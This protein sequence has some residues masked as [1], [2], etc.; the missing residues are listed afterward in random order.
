MGKGITMTIVFQAQSL[1]YG[2]GVSNISELKKLTRMDG[3]QYTFVSRQAIRFDIVR[4]GHEIFEWNLQVVDKSKGTVQF[5]E[6]ATIKDSV[7]MDLFGYMKT[8]KKDEE[9]KGGSFVRPAVVRLSNAISLEPYRSD[10]DFLSNKGLADRI[11]EHP[12]LANSEQHMS[13]YTYTV[14]IDLDRIGVDNEISLEKTER[15]KRI[16]QLLDIIKI[17]NRNIRGRQENLSPLF[18]I[19]GLYK[20]S[21]P[22]FLGR[23]KLENRNG[24]YSINENIIKDTLE[25]TFGDKEIKDDTYIGIVDGIFI[26]KEEFEKILPDK[27]VNVEKFFEILKEKVKAYYGV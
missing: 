12:N 25:L 15:A 5:K 23:V 20:I 1:N 22:F 7:E 24:K 6:D 3:N 8:S 26:N 18:I 2:E 17:L 11:G 16:L 14:T 4:L 9:N 27:V 19:G 13:F 21:N 10:M